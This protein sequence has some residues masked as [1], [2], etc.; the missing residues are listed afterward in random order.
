M[1]FESATST[2]TP[3]RGSSCSAQPSFPAAIVALEKVYRSEIALR[4]ELGARLRALKVEYEAIDAGMG[5]VP[6]KINQGDS[7][8]LGHRELRAYIKRVEAFATR[9]LSRN[10]APFT[11]NLR[12]YSENASDAFDAHDERV[13]NGEATDLQSVLDLYSPLNCWRAVAA[14]FNPDAQRQVANVQAAH[15]IRDEFGLYFNPGS[16]KLVGGRVELQTRVYLHQN[17]HKERTLN[18]GDN[19]QKLGQALDQACAHA[20]LQVSFGSCLS[21]WCCHL[22]STPVVSRK[23]IDLGDGVD[24]VLGYEHFKFY[25]PQ[26]IAAAINTFLAEHPTDRH[27]YAV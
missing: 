5:Y 26:P 16:M 7:I 27:G 15:R 25:L 24:L 22:T 17:Y 19:L 11:G 13:G 2:D 3:S 10:G 8:D 23:R 6:I 4:L 18:Y 14:Q 20:G 21:S 1:L 12:D 9:E